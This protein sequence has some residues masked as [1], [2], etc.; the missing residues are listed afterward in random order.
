M[1]IAMLENILEIRSTA[2]GSITSPMA[3]VTKDHGT[4]VRSRVSECTLSEMELCDAESG[5]AEF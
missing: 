3:T 1:V 4:K 5:I 2:L